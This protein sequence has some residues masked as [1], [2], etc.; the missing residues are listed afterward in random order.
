MVDIPA[1]QK[2][3]IY[4]FEK[5][6]MLQID[7]VQAQAKQQHTDNTVGK[8]EVRYKD[9][10][11]MII[12]LQVDHV[13]QCMLRD[14]ILGKINDIWGDLPLVNSWKDVL[15]EGI[16]RGHTNWQVLGSNKPFNIPYKLTHIY[17]ASVDAENNVDYEQV[18]IK[19]F[20]MKNNWH[21]M[22][23]RNKE[24]FAPE[25][26]SDIKQE[27]L[28]LKQNFSKQHRTTGGGLGKKLGITNHAINPHEI[29][30]VDDLDLALD[31]MFEDSDLSNYYLQD[32]HNYIMILPEEYYGPGSY[33][34]WIKVGIALKH[35]SPCMF[36]SWLKFSSQ[37][38]EF[39]YD[40][41]GELYET[42]DRI[43]SKKNE[44]TNRSIMYWAKISN[45]KEYQ[46]TKMKTIDHF[47][48][49]TLHTSTEYDIASV[50]Y[51]LFKD[52]YVCSNI[53][54]NMWYEYKNHRWREIDSGT[55]L[56]LALSRDLYNIYS[57]K[58]LKFMNDVH[59]LNNVADADA[60]ASVVLTTVATQ[61]SAIKQKTNQLFG[62]E[63]VQIKGNK[64][65]EVCLMLKR[66][67]HKNN[68]M[69]EARDIF[70]DPKFIDKLDTNTR[71]LGCVNGVVDFNEKSF[72][73]GRPEDYISKNTNINYRALDRAKSCVQIE[74]INAFMMELFPE[75]EL[76]KYMWEHLS[77][78][79]IG[80]NENQTFHIYKGKGSNGKSKLIELMGLILGEYK[81][82]IP[83]TLITQKRNGIGSTSSEIIQLM[84][85][86][87]AVMQEPSKGERVN[88]GVL[89][90][91][92]GC[93]PI[94]GR[95]LFHE[96]QTFIPQFKLVVCT[97][98]LF[99]VGSE[100]DAT[101]RR[102]RMVDYKSKFCENPVDDDPTEPYQFPI[103]KR[104]D[105]KFKEWKEVMLSMLVE[106]AYV[107]EGNVEDCSIVMAASKKYRT[108]QDYF[109][110]FLEERIRDA[111]DGKIMKTELREEFKAWYNIE[112]GNDLPK[113]KELFEY[114][115]NKYG[116]YKNGWHGIC[117]IY[118][119]DVEVE[120]DGGI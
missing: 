58:M 89:K 34:N 66:T 8:H 18:S 70:Y 115:E 82:L 85:A 100:D 77:S 45:P 47:I 28:S 12:G 108:G 111:H 103:N 20:D 84:G 50:L 88:E 107:S 112:Y 1:N 17:D 72:R 114:F 120:V 110:A 86:R 52:R 81:V 14:R 62:G 109:A 6:S 4:V 95:K 90:E 98:T 43:S 94:Q 59:D 106:K 10:I 57:Q 61:K 63:D 105:I 3:P 102:I 32:T 71:L 27:Y 35:T 96:S 73:V 46:E 60:S 42:W 22:S 116:K 9:G 55:T 48:E 83:V 117:V 80:I 97:N 40:N 69:R 118:E 37:S 49:E 87:L 68:I 13:V 64:Y 65:A 30:N 19:D 39:S 53:K 113:G 101:W 104:I 79:L 29:N 36:L 11:H 75:E 25:L 7:Q 16:S 76:R 67:M 21:K 38:S 41:V 51:T 5:T 93:D 119:G 91:M 92:T 15:D 2:I 99:D 24:H 26:K 56:R 31:Q 44:I 33:G 23:V 54:N 74:E 78:C